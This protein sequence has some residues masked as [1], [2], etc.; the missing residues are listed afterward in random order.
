MGIGLLVLGRK[1]K[2]GRILAVCGLALLV[3]QSLPIVSNSYGGKVKR[4]Y[5][6]IVR[7][8][9]IPPDVRWVVVL[10]GAT[11]DDPNMPITSRNVGDTLH[12]VAEG[13][14]LAWRIPEA[15]LLL[16]GGELRDPGSQDSVMA[17]LARELRFPPERIVV[18]NKG[19]DTEEQARAI[20]AMIGKDKF[21][22]VTALR[23]MER[24]MELLQGY[25]LDPVA[26]PTANPASAYDTLA[27]QLFP[28]PGAAAAS[29]S[30]AHELIGMAWF[31]AK[32]VLK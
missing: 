22:L 20:A 3:V 4:A 31:K 32:R 12:R 10:S 14:I 5:P 24:S 15:R 23:H 11:I 28:N 21:I 6:P 29:A 16:S 7:D 27:G 19:R 26:A 2:A 1:V 30:L 18:E 25:G 17:Q 9:D 8:A 13:V